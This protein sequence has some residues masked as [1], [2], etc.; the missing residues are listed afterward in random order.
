MKT[1]IVMKVTPE[2]SRKVQEIAITKGAS[3]YG[4]KYVKYI[5]MQQLFIGIDKNLSANSCW[6][7]YQAT[8]Y[9]Q[10][11]PELF[12]RT[13]GTCEEWKPEP[14]EEIMVWY[15]NE[16]KAVKREFISMTKDDK[17]F[18]CHDYYGHGSV[19]WLNAKPAP[20]E[21][22]ET[23]SE[24]NPVLCWVSDKDPNAKDSA[25]WVTNY[26]DD[27]EYLFRTKYESYKYATPVMCDDLSV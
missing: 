9:E 5:E 3:W 14:G 26:L 20:K 13:D 6:V 7:D 12:I 10:V 18:I 1:H 4:D 25:K 11:D 17:K 22:Y 16:T 2:Q 15:N 8:S 24:D 23:I 21:W 19:D 27:T